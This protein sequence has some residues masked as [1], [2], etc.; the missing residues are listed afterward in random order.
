M[1]LKDSYEE[2]KNTGRDCEPSK[3]IGADA[4][5]AALFIRSG[6]YFH[7]KRKANSG[8]EALVL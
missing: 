5:V 6:L 3:E 8:T 1:P 2:K 7:I 4:P